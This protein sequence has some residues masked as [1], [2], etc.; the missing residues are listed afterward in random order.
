[1]IL[2]TG[3]TGLVGSHLLLDLVRAGKPV[4]ALKY[5]P[6]DIKF[7]EMVF[8][9]YSD[10]AEELLNKI[11]WFEGDVLDIFCL[12]EAM[13]GVDYVY[14]SAAIVSYQPRQKNIMMK[15][16]VDGTANIVNIAL[17]KK[18]RKLCHVSSIAS[19]GRAENNDLIDESSK[20]KASEENTNYGISKYGGERE[21]WR[22]AEEGLDVV[23]VNPSIIIGL[24]N[25]DKGS[26][27][28]FSTIW[29]GLKFYT[30]GTNG[31]V[32]VRD[33]VRAM[34]MLMES[35]IKNERFILNAAN[36]YYKELFDMM[37]DCF[38]RPGPNIKVNNSM[39]AIVWRI[40]KASSLLT[41]KTPVITRE[42]ALTAMKEYRYSNEKIRK[43]LG[44]EFIDIRKTIEETC[45]IFR[46]YYLK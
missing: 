22:A 5:P 32:D 23:I 6:D 31:Y 43:K 45:N 40:V 46:K 13:D 30:P 41:G 27:Q 37:A 15:V 38:G 16:N 2:V 26:I 21:V 11:E 29:K 18:V 20:W 28:L 9:H 25:F 39:S 1:M 35:D 17:D 12:K 34:I 3:G 24:A 14:H 42:T 19:L 44:F 33:V 8:H 36:L 4:R 7:T 10:N